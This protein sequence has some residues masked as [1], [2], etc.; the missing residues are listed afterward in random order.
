MLTALLLGAVAGP[1]VL[2]PATMAVYWF[3]FHPELAGV[4]SVWHFLLFRLR[5]GF[6]AP[7]LAMSGL[8][9]AMGGM[10]GA[11]IGFGLAAIAWS[12]RRIA[13][14]ERELSHT[15]PA[16]LAAGEGECLEFKA[17]VRW[18]REARRVNRALEEP[19]VRTIAG[20]MN[21]SGGTLLLGVDDSAQVVGLAED[22]ATLRRPTKDGFE[23]YL[24]TLVR[25]ALGTHCCPLVHVV[26]HH[27]DGRDVCRVVVE[28][29]PEA[30]FIERDGTAHYFVRAGNATRALDPRETLIHMQRR[31][32]PR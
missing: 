12:E 3:E 20:F 21:Q 23:Q 27:I 22:F 4:T 16:L 6:T 25:T 5:A 15:L 29:A 1:L 11:V 17:S 7:M 19:V 9:A 18:D 10:L 30:V 2:H 31:Q 26:F 14:L 8:F 13:R 24:V 28:P 32:A